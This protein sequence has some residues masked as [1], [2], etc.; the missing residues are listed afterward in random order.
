M[1]RVARRSPE[2]NSRSA[3]SWKRGPVCRELC[4]D[5]TDRAV[6]GLHRS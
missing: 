6:G 3:T 2:S 5:R 1:R 4:L